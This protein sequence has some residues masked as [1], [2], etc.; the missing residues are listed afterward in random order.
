MSGGVFRLNTDIIRDY[1]VNWTKKGF[2]LA[3]PSGRA[4]D[5]TSIKSVLWRKPF[6]SDLYN[7]TDHEDSFFYSECRYAVREMYNLCRAAGAN[8]LVEEG[9]ER[10][11]GKPRQLAIAARYFQVPDWRIVLGIDLH[12]SQNIIVKS[13]SGDQV[14]GD[15]VLYTSRVDG[16]T[17]DKSH[18][19][20]TQQAINKDSDLTVVYVDGSCFGFECQTFANAVDWREKISEM[21]IDDWQLIEL[22]SNF[23]KNI[24]SFM[25]E[26]GLR[27]GRLDFVT[28]GQSYYFLEVNP[29]GQWAWLDLSGKNGLLAAMVMAVEGKTQPSIV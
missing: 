4:V 22:D 28:K 11:L 19:W 21:S 15:S 7:Q 6:N 1:Y 10:R 24:Q 13:M 5:S 16:E 2:H 3:D 17:L 14:S 27:Y 25:R 29:N 26:C 12:V 23:I 9:A 20:L 8:V 18:I